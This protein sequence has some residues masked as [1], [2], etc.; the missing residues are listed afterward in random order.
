MAII[1]A[2]DPVVFEDAV[3]TALQNSLPAPVED[4]QHGTRSEPSVVPDE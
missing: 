4:P 2:D 1:A 3:L